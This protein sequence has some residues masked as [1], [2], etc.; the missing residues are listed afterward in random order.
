MHGIF[1]WANVRSY[2]VMLCNTVKLTYG[3]QVLHNFTGF[4][5]TTHLYQLFDYV[6]LI[7]NKV[8]A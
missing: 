2:C 5:K 3:L 4:A 8:L 1:A 7:S 6:T